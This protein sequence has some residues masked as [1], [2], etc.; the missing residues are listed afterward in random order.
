MTVGGDIGSLQTA[1]GLIV[2]NVYQVV[3]AVAGHTY[4]GLE[5]NGM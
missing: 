2:G 3:G 4:A 5:S 1:G